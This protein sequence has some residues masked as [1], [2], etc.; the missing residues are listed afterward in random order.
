MMK[1][2]MDGNPMMKMM[3]DNP[4]MLKMMFSIYSTNIR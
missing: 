2:M 3:L 4:A 1:S